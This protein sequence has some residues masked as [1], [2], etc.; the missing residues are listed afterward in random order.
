MGII[1]Q[2]AEGAAEALAL[3]KRE[4]LESA[5]TFQNLFTQMGV[6]AAKSAQMSKSMITLAGDFGPS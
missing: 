1:N 6:G 3:S 4:A 5:S 2:F